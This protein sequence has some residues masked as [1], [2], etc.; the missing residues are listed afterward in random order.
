MFVKQ[1]RVPILWKVVTEGQHVNQLH[2]V[3]S[4]GEGTVTKAAISVERQA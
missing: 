1:D 3:W 4:G 2:V